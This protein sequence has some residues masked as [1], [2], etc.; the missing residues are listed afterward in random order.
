MGGCVCGLYIWKEK[1]ITARNESTVPALITQ[2]VDEAG[3]GSC[4]YFSFR[5]CRAHPRRG[6]CPLATS[7]RFLLSEGSFFLYRPTGPRLPLVGEEAFWGEEGH[8]GWDSG[9]WVCV[10]LWLLILGDRGG[11]VVG[12][13]WMLASLPLCLRR[14]G[15][16]RFVGLLEKLPLPVINCRSKPDFRS[17]L[18]TL[19]Y[20][21]APPPLLPLFRWSF[22][23]QSDRAP[24]YQ[25]LPNPPSPTPSL[26]LLLLSPPPD[27]PLLPTV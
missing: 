1:T 14:D 24:R 22:N 4:Q 12:E 26:I 15:A 16:R 10:L 25:Q 8:P 21:N 20:P 3:P 27:A 7:S 5:S 19:P 6:P 2:T 23:P 17:P 13:P 11:D 18:P 9:A